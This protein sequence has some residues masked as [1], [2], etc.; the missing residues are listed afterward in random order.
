MFCSFEQLAF[1]ENI[2]YARFFTFTPI[3]II[4]FVNREFLAGADVLAVVE[5]KN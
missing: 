4:T 1:I 3:I 5:V 2:S